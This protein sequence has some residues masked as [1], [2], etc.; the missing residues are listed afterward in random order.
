MLIPPS[1]WRTT[2]CSTGR[3]RRHPSGARRSRPQRQHRS[4]GAE[5]FWGC[6]RCGAAASGSAATEGVLPLRGMSARSG[7]R[8]RNFRT[9]FVRR[10]Q[11][12]SGWA[13]C[14]SAPPSS[15]G[16]SRVWQGYLGQRNGKVTKWGRGG[17]GMKNPPGTQR[18]CRAVV[19]GTMSEDPT[20]PEPQL[21]VN[22]TMFHMEQ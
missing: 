9:A 18:F 7:S 10:S 1:P 15:G 21:R 16:P 2:R 22:Q 17:R 12:G 5:N 19:H 8:A 20:F 4:R 11:K 14:R 3:Q 6:R 13:G